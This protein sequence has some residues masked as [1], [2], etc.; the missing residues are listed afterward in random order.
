MN[1]CAQNHSPTREVTTKSSAYETVA[2][3]QRQTAAGERSSYAGESV[4]MPS[5]GPP[6]LVFFG[7]GRL[8]TVGGHAVTILLPLLD[9]GSSSSQ[10]VA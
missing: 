5:G 4:V 2:H 1:I 9:Q 6:T 10:W 3:V 8:D 7:G